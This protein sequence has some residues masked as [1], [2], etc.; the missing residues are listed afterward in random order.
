MDIII[1]RKTL[2]LDGSIKTIDDI[3][4]ISNKD[5]YELENDI[6]V[7]FSKDNN[8]YQIFYKDYYL[9]SSYRED[10]SITFMDIKNVVDDINHLFNITNFGT[11]KTELAILEFKECE[12]RTME[13]LEK[14]KE[15]YENIRNMKRLCCCDEV[16]INFAQFDEVTAFKLKKSITETL[17][18]REKEIQKVIFR[19]E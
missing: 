7:K 1:K 14:Y 19:A 4:P 2:Q 6:N 9:V 5:Y 8:L 17:N 16:T 15:S 12:V 3:I 18:V 11:D 10:G 13:G